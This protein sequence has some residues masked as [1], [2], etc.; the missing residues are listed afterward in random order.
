MSSI[1]PT[2]KAFRI[3][4]D[5]DGYH[6]GLDSVSISDLSEGEVTLQV[7]WSGIN[8]KD[9]LAATGKGRILRRYPLCGGIDVAGTV[10]ESSCPEVEP[11]DRVLANGSGLSEVRDGGY[12]EYLRLPGDIIVPLPDG[13]SMRE[14]MGIGTAGFTAA[15]SLDRMQTNGQEPEMGPIV[16]TGASGGVGT[17]A[18]DLLTAAGYEVHAITGKV[19]EF[20]WLEHLGARQCISRHDLHWG[21]KPLE[22]TKWAG[23]IDSV[24]GDMLAGITRVIE[25]WGNIAVCGMAGHHSLNATV[26]PMILRGVSLLGISSANCP[27]K[28]RRKLWERLGQEWKP[29]HL[30]EIIRQEVTLES[31]EI[32]FN[33]MLE[34]R[35]LGRT[36]VKIGDETE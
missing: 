9:A 25:P 33:D 15:M 13:L 14:A 34:G 28:L 29:P 36:V 17:V 11:G 35:S 22:T 6:S 8:Y 19:E 18:I 12:S 7:A 3:H 24:G 20:D 31:M 16:V 32:V 1:P 4:N 26:F 23:C 30:D 5:D 27:I 21:Q 2:F 10:V